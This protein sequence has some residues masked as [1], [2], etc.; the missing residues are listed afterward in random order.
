MAPARI[1]ERNVRAP[2]RTQED[3]EDVSGGREYED[4]AVG[5]ED[6]EDDEYGS[7]ME[8]NHSED[9]VVDGEDEDGLGGDVEQRI[10]SISFG[11]LKQAQDAVSRKRK[12]GS[13]E[14]PEQDDK[15][16]ALRKRLRQI[17]EQKAASTQVN[18]VASKTGGE[19][20]DSSDSDSAPSEEDLPSK[21]RTSKH[22]PAEQTSRHQVTRKR[23]VVDFPKRVIRDPRFDSLPHQPSTTNQPPNGTTDKAYSFLL[24]YQRTEIDDLKI[25]FKRTKSEDDRLTLRRKINSME[26]R[27]KA[28]AAKERE[29]AVRSA[30]RKEEKGRVLE[31]K[32]PYYLKE[33]EVK[34]RALVEKFKGMK[35]REREKVVEKRRLKESQKEKRGMPR[36]R[37]LVG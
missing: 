13:D 9:E 37:R 35:G 2:Q 18:P 10:S 8:N 33:K 7:E 17:K 11:A 22:A 5:D 31:G 6:G 14:A 25:A 21:S 15:L 16:A 34:E 23:T 3:D 28:H 29:Q 1:L 27:L 30:H 4:L 20:D 12:R 32:K 24:D 19:S 36:D 26:N